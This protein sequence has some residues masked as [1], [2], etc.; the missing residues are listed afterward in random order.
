MATYTQLHDLWRRTHNCTIYNN[1]QTIA[2]FMATCS[3]ILLRFKHLGL[4]LHSW[5]NVIFLF[6][7][8]GFLA[9]YS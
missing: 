8:T 7:K 3:T 6:K 1:V 5:H 4:P 2:R 9:N